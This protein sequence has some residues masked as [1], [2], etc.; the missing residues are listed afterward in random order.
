[1]IDTTKLIPRSKPLNDIK[2]D[3]IEIDNLLKE[4]LV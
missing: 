2:K 1:M 3:V 4:R